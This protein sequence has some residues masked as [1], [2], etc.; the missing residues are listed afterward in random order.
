[1]AHCFPSTT[2]SR[3]LRENMNMLLCITALALITLSFAIIKCPELNTDTSNPNRCGPL[4][5][6]VRCNMYLAEYDQ[7]AFY[8]NP[9]SGWCEA[10]PIHHP[11]EDKYDWN[12]RSCVIIDALTT[13][14]DYYMISGEMIRTHDQA[15]TYCVARS[16]HLASIHNYTEDQYSRTLCRTKRTHKVVSDINWDDIDTD[17]SYGCWIGLIRSGR[18]WKWVDGSPFDYGSDDDGQPTKGKTPWHSGEPNGD[19]YGRDDDCTHLASYEYLS[20]EWNDMPCKRSYFP[21]SYI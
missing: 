4:F 1:M 11:N 20:Y 14:S 13:M 10:K 19:E 15:E 3:L 5:G 21:Q 12:P 2:T 6:N 8:C 7:Y 18:S 16:S 17:S 9:D